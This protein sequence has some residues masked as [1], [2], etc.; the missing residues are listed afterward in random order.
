MNAPDLLARC[1][2]YAPQLL[3]GAL[4]TLWLSALAVCCGFFAGIFVYTMSVGKS[5]GLAGAARVY[6]SVFRGTPVLAQL[7]VFY[8]VPSALGID[9]PGVVAAAV[10]LSLNTA[11]Y[12][13]QI[14][15][16]GFRAIPRGQ[17]E[18]AQ[19]F[20]LTRQQVL[21]HVEVPQVVR[22]TLPALVSEMIDIVKASAVVSVI[23]V[24]DLM[25]VGQ[26]LSSSSYRPLEVYSLA[27]LF[28]LAITTLLSVAGHCY[29]RR[30]A[31]RA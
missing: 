23:S 31:R 29:A 11:A 19:T 4:T 6:V 12:Q 30:A 8:Y 27:A 5:R 16:A 9:L 24:T 3:Q 7:L 13:S 2:G 10:G 17:I 15:A 28:Y 18:A 20:N 1:A 22:A 25:R 26:Q 14:L 21:W